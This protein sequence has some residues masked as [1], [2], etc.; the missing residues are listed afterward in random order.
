VIVGILAIT[1]WVTPVVAQDLG[2][3]ESFVTGSTR[4]DGPGTLVLLLLKGIG[5]TAEQKQQVKSVF[6]THRGNLEALFRELQSAN[7]DLTKTLFAAE[8]VRAADIAPHAERVT[9]AR[10]RLLQEGLTVVLEVRQILTPEQRAK[11]ARL[12]EQLHKLQGAWASPP[13]EQSEK[14]IR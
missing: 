8:E 13:Q 7:A 2:G 14:S 9:L 4:G 1:L 5:L 6:M 10:Q 3:L 11:A 12:R